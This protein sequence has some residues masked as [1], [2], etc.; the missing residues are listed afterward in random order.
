MLLKKAK[1]ILLSTQRRKAWKGTF[2][3]DW[4]KVGVEWSRIVRQ[5]IDVPLWKIHQ[6]FS[7]RCIMLWWQFIF[8]FLFFFP[9]YLKDIERQK[10]KNEEKMKLYI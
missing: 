7:I 2:Y 8:P 5:S 6:Q 10:A 1:E 3:H 9:I 4:V